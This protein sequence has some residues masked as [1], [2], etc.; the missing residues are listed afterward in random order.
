MTRDEELLVVKRVLSGDN[1][2]YE[3]LVNAHQRQVYNLALKMLGDP[4]DAF[5]MSQEAFLRA[6]SSLSSFRGDSKFSVWL[7]RLTSNICIDY[8]RRKKR[9]MTSSLTYIDELGH[10]E[11]IEIPDERFSP[12]TQ[13]ERTQLREAVVAAMDALSEEYR[14][15]LIL[16]EINGLSYDEIG[17]VLDLEAGTVKSRLF[18]ARKRICSILTD[19]NFYEPSASKRT[20]KEV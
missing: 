20:E 6:Y 10:T 17:E 1:D 11:E 16:R 7:Y 3:L 8:L 2:A 12:E 9:H 14:S 19:G 4:D 5:D 15:I 13:L 18:R